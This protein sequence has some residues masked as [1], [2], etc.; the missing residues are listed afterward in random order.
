[1]LADLRYALR[2]FLN[3]PG[4]ASIAILT[5]ALGAGANTVIFSAVNAVLLKPL[6][7][8]DADRLT[9]IWGRNLKEGRDR[10]PLSLDTYHQ[11]AAMPDQD[12]IGA[13]SPSWA[14]TART[15]Q[16]PEQFQGYWATASF[17]KLLGV[18]PR[19]GRLFDEADD[20]V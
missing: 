1:M 14:F 10:Q 7:F 9:I 2:T 13:V 3:T 6:R 19:L 17:L 4:L 18:E 20:R 5:V 15:P 8:A 12:G 11:L 16:G